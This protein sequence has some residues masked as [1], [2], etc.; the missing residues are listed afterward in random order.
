MS[1][2]FSTDALFISLRLQS[3]G[4]DIVEGNSCVSV[5]GTNAVCQCSHYCRDQH[6]LCRSI[7]NPFVRKSWV[8]HDYAQNNE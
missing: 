3:P 5:A 1:E 6:Y 4:G 7:T 2:N 8:M